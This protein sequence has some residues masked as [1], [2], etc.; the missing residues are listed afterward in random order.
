MPKS[1]ICLIVS[2][3]TIGL[4]VAACDSPEPDPD[5]EEAAQEADPS[6]DNPDDWMDSASSANTAW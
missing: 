6:G 2:L 1:R 5:E 3:F 4:T